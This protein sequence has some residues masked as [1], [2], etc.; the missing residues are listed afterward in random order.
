MRRKRGQTSKQMAPWE[1]T[2][3]CEKLKDAILKGDF[4]AFTE[5][6]SGVSVHSQ[7]DSR[8]NIP[9]VLAASCGH[10]DILRS[11]LD[12]GALVDRPNRDGKT[13]LMAAASEGHFAAVKLLLERGACARTKM[14]GLESTAL[15][16][17]ANALCYDSMVA[18]IEAGAD[19]NAR[20]VFGASP[21]RGA[22]LKSNL[23]AVKL[24]LKYG[25]DP[26]FAEDFLGRGWRYVEYE[27]VDGIS[28]MLQAV[29]MHP[30]STSPEIKQLL[31]KEL[32]RRYAAA[33]SVLPDRVPEPVRREIIKLVKGYSHM[34]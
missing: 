32:D 20:T 3:H 31:Q 6:A 8:G 14:L 26:H 5:L 2:F 10:M 7:I 21:L 16:E 33:L 29:S 15:F 25:A 17:A 24:L 11:L 30:P 22:C 12:S 1:R 9:L 23:A 4:A 19:V 18:L 13:A 27:G 34:M 28:A